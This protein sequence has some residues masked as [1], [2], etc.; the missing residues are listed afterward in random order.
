MRMP[1]PGCRK[2]A[3]RIDDRTDKPGHILTRVKK[4]RVGS[5]SPSKLALEHSDEGRSKPLRFLIIKG[6]KKIGRQGL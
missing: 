6:L 3:L 1:D 5:Y 2:Q 4:W